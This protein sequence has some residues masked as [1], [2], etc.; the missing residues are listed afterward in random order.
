MDQRRDPF[1]W[2][3]RTIA[4]DT[5]SVDPLLIVHAKATIARHGCKN[6]MI[7]KNAEEREPERAK[8]SSL[9]LT[10]RPLHASKSHGSK[11]SCA[12]SEVREPKRSG[13]RTG[14]RWMK[15]EEFFCFLF[16]YS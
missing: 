10:A 16:F 8:P 2:I 7:D 9:S 3:W 1:S 14:G 12:H 13:E 4:K 6:E 15:T 5:L 11:T